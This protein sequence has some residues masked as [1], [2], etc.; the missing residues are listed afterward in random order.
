MTRAIS[1][2]N[3][4]NIEQRIAVVLALAGRA[5]AVALLARRRVPG[6][7]P[8][9]DFAM[10]ER[11]YAEAMSVMEGLHAKGLLHGTDLETLENGRK[12]LARIRQE[13]AAAAT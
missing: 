10:A 2:A 13:R 8:A 5:D 3:P 11:D 1:A 12:E 6:S 9:A 7:T 4:A